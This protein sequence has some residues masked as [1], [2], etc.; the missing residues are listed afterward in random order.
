MASQEA[1]P[2]IN[3]ATERRLET[4]SQEL[5][6][7][8]GIYIIKHDDTLGAVAKRFGTSIEE[9]LKWN[10]QIKDPTRIEP[11]IMIRIRECQRIQD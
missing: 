4:I 10:P 6:D 5:I 1:P 11:V 9:L 2:T 8:F 3:D 7:R